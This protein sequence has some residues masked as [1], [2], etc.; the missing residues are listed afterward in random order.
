[1][2][3]L[4]IV[5]IDEHIFHNIA[6]V[7]GIVL[8]L[9]LFLYNKNQGQLFFGL[10]LLFLSIAEITFL[11]Y[12]IDSNVVYYIGTVSYII[13]YMCLFNH[14][15]TDMSSKQLFKKFV[16][17]IIVLM[18]LGIYLFYELYKMMNYHNIELPTPYYILELSYN[19]F[20]VFVLIFSFLHYIY[21]MSKKALIFFIACLAL[22][23]SEL[24]QFSFLFIEEV[25][26]LKVFYSTN[27]F[28][29]SLF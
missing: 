25:K 14:C 26:T 12:Y 29:P 10:F 5:F 6:R 2:A 11:F 3:Y 19:L 4:T 17:H 9:I 1:M 15:I 8:I 18:C 21:H 7:I 13:S 24:I 28:L 27:T 20:V 23:C 16:F 22:T